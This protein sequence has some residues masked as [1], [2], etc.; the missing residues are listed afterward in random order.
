MRCLCN[1]KRLYYPV[2]SRL[3]SSPLVL[4]DSFEYW[5]LKQE[6][7]PA[8]LAYPSFILAETSRYIPCSSSLSSG[9]CSVYW[10]IGTSSPATFMACFHFG[11]MITMPTR[12]FEPE[13]TMPLLTFRQLMEVRTIGSSI[14]SP[15]V[16]G[17]PALTSSISNVIPPSTLIGVSP[18]VIEQKKQEA[19]PTVW[20]IILP[21]LADWPQRRIR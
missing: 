10:S 20:G 3:I 18:S 14:V 16:I 11:E 1:V 8:T 19:R 13:H 2:V 6:A 4:A 17:F 9:T 15:T 7:R 5:R 21:I 12:F